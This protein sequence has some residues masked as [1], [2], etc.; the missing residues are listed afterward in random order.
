MDA[1]LKALKKRNQ[2]YYFTCI[3]MSHVKKKEYKRI[4][5]VHDENFAICFSD[6]WNQYFLPFPTILYDF[7][8]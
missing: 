5:Y 4:R 1:R 3:F 2:F 8:G 6:M 7:F